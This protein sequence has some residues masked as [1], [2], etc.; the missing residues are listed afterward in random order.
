MYYYLNKLPLIVK[1][2]KTGNNLF[3]VKKIGGDNNELRTKT[4]RKQN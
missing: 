1:N 2:F 3:I 4:F